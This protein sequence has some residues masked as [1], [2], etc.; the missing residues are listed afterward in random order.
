MAV[1]VEARSGDFFSKSCEVCSDKKM[2]FVQTQKYLGIA[3]YRV[4]GQGSRKLGG[5]CINC[6]TTYPLTKQQ[7]T[8]ALKLKYKERGTGSTDR[9]LS[10]ERPKY[11]PILKNDRRV[12]IRAENRKQG[13]LS[14]AIGFI[15]G[16]AV[17]VPPFPITRISGT[18]IIVYSVL[19]GLYGILEDPERKHRSWIDHNIK[20]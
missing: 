3:G 10:Q 19:G 15:I 20:K 11:Y 1:R 18:I 13:V 2:E 17:F 5:V 12:K 4:F 16:L 9:L 8:K 6:N 14:M 7:N